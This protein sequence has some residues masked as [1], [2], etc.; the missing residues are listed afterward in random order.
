MRAAILVAVLLWAGAVRAEEPTPVLPAISAPEPATCAVLRGKWQCG[1]PAAIQQAIDICQSHGWDLTYGC[2]GD[3]KPDIAGAY[4]TNEWR[5][6]CLKVFQ[7]W[8][9]E[10]Y[11][12]QD[13]REQHEKDAHDLNF[14]RGVAGM[15]P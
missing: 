14:L 4:C 15:K 11:A 12:E 9:S 3:R 2:F 5:K 1:W 7:R 10:G 6:P 8:R 13:A